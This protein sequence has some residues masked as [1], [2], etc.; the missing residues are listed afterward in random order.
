VSGAHLLRRIVGGGAEARI[1]PVIAVTFT[2]AVFSTFWVY[3]GVFA[4]KGL[5]AAVNDVGLLF[6]I[7]APPAAA[8]NYAS[9]AVS[10]RIGRR[11]LIV[12]SFV[13]SG[14]NMTVLWLVREHVAVAFALIVLQGVAGAP[15][16]SLDR[17]LVADFVPEPE[18]REDAYATVRV[19]NNLGI[20]VGPP[21]AALLIHLGGWSAFLLGE[22]VVA[23]VGAAVTILIVPRRAVRARRERPPISVL[24]LLGRDRPFSLLLVS[25]LLGFAIYVGY[26]TVLPVVAVSA[27]GL[28]SSTW[29]L[30]L[31][32]APLLVVTGQ[33]RLTRATAGIDAASRLAAAMLLMGLP[34]L[35]LIAASNVALIAAVIVVFVVGEMLWIPTSQALAAELAPPALR[36]T[37]FGA[38]AAMTG[39]AWTL[40]PLIA[41]QV[42]AAVGVAAVWL[43]FAIA[44]VVGA[45]VGVAAACA[46]QHPRT[47][48]RAE[49]RPRRRASGSSGRHRRRTWLGTLRRCRSQRPDR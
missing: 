8:A 1:R 31:I 37:Y 43:F 16:Y 3:V 27:Y 9:G 4:V 5:G 46:A 44:A 10:D 38:L 19:A 49:L 21:L 26:E 47:V 13:A 11:G 22:V 30:L 14:L 42:R 40:V 34:F 28:S 23:I 48:M 25:T 29:G 2:Y 36:G 33:L 17:V 12:G 7:T 20:L 45:A 32:I 41:L 35:A 15:A 18:L 24:R 6:L 39:P